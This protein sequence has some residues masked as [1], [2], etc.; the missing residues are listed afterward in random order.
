MLGAQSYKNRSYIWYKK[1]IYRHIV[2]QLIVSTKKLVPPKGE[3]NLR[4]F[5]DNAGSQ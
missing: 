3:F 1:T 2:N 4:F 5:I